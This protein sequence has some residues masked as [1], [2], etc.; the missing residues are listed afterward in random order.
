MFNTK[1]IKQLEDKI[2]KIS[3]FYAKNMEHQNL[4]IRHIIE[5]CKPDIAYEVRVEDMKLM[6]DGEKYRVIKKLILNKEN[7]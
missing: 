2:E 1:K 7:N 6:E 3:Y 5:N 4:L